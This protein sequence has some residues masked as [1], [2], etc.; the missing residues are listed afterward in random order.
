MTYSP[1]SSI[2]TSLATTLKHMKN[3]T[4]TELIDI[5]FELSNLIQFTQKRWSGVNDSVSSECISR[6]FN[7]GLEAGKFW[8]NQ[9]G[10]TDSFDAWKKEREN[11]DNWEPGAHVTLGLIS[12]YDQIIEFGKSFFFA[13]AFSYMGIIQEKWS[14]SDVVNEIYQSLKK[15]FP[16]LSKYKPTGWNSLKK[17]YNDFDGYKEYKPQ[18]KID[19]VEFNGENSDSAVSGGFHERIALPCVMY[20]EMGQGIKA[21]K[22]LIGAAL[23]HGIFVAS[24]NNTADILA[25]IEK[26]KKNLFTKE[27]FSRI[28]FLGNFSDYSENKIMKTFHL[29]TQF[30]N[31]P[32]CGLTL[33]YNSQAEMDTFIENL[34]TDQSEE[35]KSNYFIKI[36]NN[37][38][39]MQIAIKNSDDYKKQLG[40]AVIK[41]LNEPSSPVKN[42]RMR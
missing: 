28:T 18:A 8:I 22:V 5:S 34:R 15:E 42:R 38:E 36:T 41:F 33:K 30:G 29:I 9:H 40:E 20:E 31:S 27:N 19:E 16:E 35:S 32:E 4:P 10:L 11:A 26:T 21:L 6:S 12:G 7:A 14:Y 39:P 1:N 17:D 25:D 2:I 13:S 37:G 23:A 24:H 3:S